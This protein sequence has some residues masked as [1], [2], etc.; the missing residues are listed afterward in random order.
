MT[1]REE[2]IAVLGEYSEVSIAF[3]VESKYIAIPS[4]CAGEWRLMEERVDA[5]WVKDYDGGESPMRWLRWDNRDWRVL[6]AFSG[7]ERVGGAIV[8]HD[9]PELDFLEGRRDLAALWDLRVA[10]E[11][12][13]FGIGTMLFEHVVRYAKRV[14]CEGRL[15]WVEDR[16][17]GHQC[18]CLRLLCET[19]LS[20]DERDSRCVSGLAR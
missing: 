4:E 11:W 19:G 14:G 20:V 1:V 17:S 2:T 7:D 5:P 15:R 3:R 6:S 10:P 12:R 18:E 16:D 9:S 8:V 13:R